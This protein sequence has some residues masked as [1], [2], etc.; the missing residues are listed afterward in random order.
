MHKNA[1]FLLKNC[2]T[3]GARPPNPSSWGLHLQP[4]IDLWQLG[5]LSLGPFQSLPQLRI[6]GY[7]IEFKNIQPQL[8]V[9]WFLE[10]SVV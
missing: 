7:A 6:P 1:L 5:V 2:P 3:L 10:K 9:Y 8:K 4:P